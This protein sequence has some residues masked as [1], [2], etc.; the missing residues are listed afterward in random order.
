M[1]TFIV[2]LLNIIV[3][4]NT[5]VWEPKFKDEEGKEVNV[6]YFKYVLGIPDCGTTQPRAIYYLGDSED[7]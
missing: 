2:T 6:K 7:E 1:N 5:G 3:F 4:N